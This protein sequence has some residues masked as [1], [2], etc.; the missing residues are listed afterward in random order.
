M[1]ILLPIFLNLKFSKKSDI[2]S[3]SFLEVLHVFGVLIFTSSM[4]FV[5]LDLLSNLYN[6]TSYKEAIFTIISLL[7][8]I[9]SLIYNIV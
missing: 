9:Y 1:F 3:I 4:V 2:N 7:L 6:I 5:S 8:L